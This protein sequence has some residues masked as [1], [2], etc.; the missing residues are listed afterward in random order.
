MQHSRKSTFGF[1]CHSKIYIKIEIKLN[2]YIQM[3]IRLKEKE[4]ILWLRY[5]VVSTC[6]HKG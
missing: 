3:N 4:D 5:R 2:V 6:N 1:T